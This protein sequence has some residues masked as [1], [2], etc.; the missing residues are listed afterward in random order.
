[1]AVATLLCLTKEAVELKKSIVKLPLFE[2][3][4][5]NLERG[6]YD[7]NFI[8]FLNFFHYRYIIFDF[9]CKHNNFFHKKESFS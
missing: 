5:L 6:D 8:W 9:M 4:F 2:M 1:M 3:M 7:F